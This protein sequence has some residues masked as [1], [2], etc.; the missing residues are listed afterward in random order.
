LDF[1][2]DHSISIVLNSCHRLPTTDEEDIEMPYKLPALLHNK[3]IPF[4]FSLQKDPWQL[5]NLP[6][7][8]GTAIAYGLPYAAAIHALT[9]TP[10]RMLRIEDVYGTLE[11]GKSATLFLSKGDPLDMI[12]QDVYLA[13][14]DGRKINLDDK[15]KQLYE[16][17][18][19]KYRMN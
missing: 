3:G 11:K 9:D 4:C 13:Y 7:Q 18:K 2:K 17:F 5:R 8:A 15:Q 10:A 1:L 6:F 14:I 16:K 12:S 19:K